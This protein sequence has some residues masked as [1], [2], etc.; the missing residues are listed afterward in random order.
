MNK[1]PISWNKG[2]WDYGDKINMG[3]DA[4]PTVYDANASGYNHWKSGIGYGN[5]LYM[6]ELRPSGN[7][8]MPYNG[9]V[10]RPSGNTWVPMVDPGYFYIDMDEYYLFS[11]KGV[12]I[13]TPTVG[14]LNLI[15]SSH[16]Y[17][18]YSAPVVVTSGASEFTPDRPFAKTYE[19]TVSGVA[20]RTPTKYRRRV[21]LSDRKEYYAVG[22]SADGIIPTPYN[23]TL[24][25]KQFTVGTS[26]TL[27]D[28]VW[29]WHIDCYPSGSSITVEYERSDIGVVAIQDVDMNP[30]NSYEVAN[31]FISVVDSSDITVK[32]IQLNNGSRYCRGSVYAKPMLLIAA[33]KDNYGCPISGVTV[34]LTGSWGSFE[35]DSIITI[36]DG[37]ASTWF[38]PTSNNV[39]G[40]LTA[41]CAGVTGNLWVPGG[42][43]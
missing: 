18:P 19:A 31:S 35:D 23:F 8:V 30:L 36:W 32:T 7:A 21:D 28:G 13:G 1:T 6:S 16:R 4:I 3:Y 20:T 33:V 2:S 9:S 24:G 11:D 17:P 39:T 34:S 27:D 38:T 43:V 40:V 37:T 22:G 25:N 15:S 10:T 42:R 12:T 29:T 5:D 14:K 26:G 41:V